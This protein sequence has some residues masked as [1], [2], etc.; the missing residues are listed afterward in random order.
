MNNC[1]L[2][3]QKITFPISI[4]F[5]LS[6]K[7]IKHKP[8]CDK[9][10]NQF[11]KIDPERICQQCGREMESS[12][13]CIDC[14]KWQSVGNSLINRSVYKYNDAMKEY[15][16][17]Y[18]FTGDYNLRKSFATEFCSHIDTKK[19][20]VPIPVSE[21]TMAERRFNQVIGLLEKIEI[22]EALNINQESKTRQSSL[23]RKQ[24]LKSSQVFKI[25]DNMKDVIKDKEIIIVDDIYTTGTT[26]HH[27]A[28]VLL[29]N[30]AKSVRG[31]TLCR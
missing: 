9:C 5:L 4:A 29:E 22:V 31:L 11:A 3:G 26:M 30:G 19:I 16:H 24:R 20:I 10:E 2:C 15:M 17:R 23:N 14:V 13:V 7:P 27:A 18:K 21:E 12:G 8:M 6:L 25:N 28:Q 1:I